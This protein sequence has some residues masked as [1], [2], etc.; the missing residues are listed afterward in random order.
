[1]AVFDAGGKRSERT[2]ASEASLACGPPQPP[3]QGERASK[4]VA[5]AAEGQA[6]LPSV[7]S[8]GIR[9]SILDDATAAGGGDVDWLAN[10][11][12]GND[13]LFPAEDY[14][15]RA[16]A[17]TVVVKH[18]PTQ[19]VRLRANGQPVK[20]LLFEGT[21]TSADKA[22]AAST[23]RAVPI[24]EGDTLLEADVIDASGGVAARL[25]RTVH[26]SG[27]AARAELMPSKSLL[28][29]DG[30]RR[31]VIAVRM[32]DQSGHPV[33]D[34]ASGNYQLSPPYLPAE[35]VE[36]QQYRQLVSAQ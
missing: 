34:G 35:T 15:P 25:S 5:A 21:T 20:P 33:R 10:Q 29:S 8:A 31:P 36:L 16:P 24:D 13:W 32:L 17:I 19:T 6:A 12:P 22:V 11:V 9:E 27:V 26:F 28:V 30:I 18:L 14:N 7:G 2:P 3:V 1:M 23:W 4:A